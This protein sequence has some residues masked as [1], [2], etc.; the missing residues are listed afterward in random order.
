[1]PAWLLFLVL[2]PLIAFLF[3]STVF[4]APSGATLITRCF[5]KAV[6]TFRALP[7]RVQLTQC[8]WHFEVGVLQQVNLKVYVWAGKPTC[9]LSCG[10]RCRDAPAGSETSHADVSIAT[11]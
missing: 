9:L 1:M 5:N 2:Q 7:F 8:E 6:Y 4:P 11:S 10:V 3:G